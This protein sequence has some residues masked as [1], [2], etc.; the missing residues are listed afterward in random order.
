MN[1]KIR[2]SFVVFLAMFCVSGYGQISEGGTPPSFKF[3]NN[4]RS[5][6]HIDEVAV[7]DIDVQRLLWQD[8]MVER[9]DKQAP[10]R[11][12]AIIDVDADIK[13]TGTWRVLP[14]STHIW[15]QTLRAPNAEGIIIT[16]NKFN[17]PEGGK[18]FIYNEDRSHVLGAYTHSTPTGDG[19]FSTEIINGDTFTLEYVASK[20]SDKEPEIELK[21]IGY[22]YNKE[23]FLRAGGVPDPGGSPACIQNIQCPIG[24]GWGDAKRGVVLFLNRTGSWWDACTGSLVNNTKQDGTPYVLTASHCF[25][26]GNKIVS[27]AIIAYFNYEAKECESQATDRPN[28]AQTMN[29]SLQ[30]LISLNGGSDGALFL[31]DGNIPASYKAYYNGW[32]RTGRQDTDGGAVIHHPERD[33]KKIT[34]FKEATSITDLP[35]VIGVEYPALS[36]GFLQIRY[37]GSGV[38]AKGSSG[39][40]LFNDKK[41]IV[42]TLTSGYST[43]G[44]LYG[45]DFYGRFYSHWNTPPDSPYSQTISEFLDPTNTGQMVLAGYDPNGLSGV[46]DIVESESKDFIIFPNPTDNEL[47]I[48]TQSVIKSVI[49]RDLM[50]RELFSNKKY[51]SS[52]TTIDVSGWSRGVYSV[53]VKTEKGQFSDKFI[54]K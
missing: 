52:T 54:K 34:T 48:N 49:I 14:D 38:T 39:S 37:D 24:Q 46:E 40:P 22:V 53:T 17:I 4:L 1:V 6:S 13:R 25:F 32:D 16:Y 31:L 12:A 23:N 45:A 26:S 33:V 10:L 2:V 43:C 7:N 21:D 35:P 28:V 8:E 15:Q 50:G 29:G 9:N 47:N 51:N 44:N 27:E 41:M 18:L 42:G 36:S 19:L 20:I 30:T 11:V 3:A 5:A